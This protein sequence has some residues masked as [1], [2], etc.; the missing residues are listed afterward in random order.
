MSVAWAG[1]FSAWARSCSRSCPS[2]EHTCWILKNHT[3]IMKKGSSSVP[4]PLRSTYRFN[5][6]GS[7]LFSPKNPQF[8]TE[9]PSVQHTPQFHT[10]NPSVPHT[11]FH[12]L[13]NYF[14]FCLEITLLIVQTQK[15]VEWKE[16]VSK[17][18]SK[19]EL[20]TQIMFGS[21]ILDILCRESYPPGAKNSPKIFLV[22][23]FFWNMPRK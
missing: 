1:L 5:T 19:K 9:N 20:L 16:I 18:C 12:T 2:L 15:L 21:S 3:L 22:A 13:G 10:K 8:H 7:L 11:H 14:I 23:M 4:H 17:R 6:K